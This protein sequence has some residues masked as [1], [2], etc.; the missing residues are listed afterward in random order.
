ML[1]EGEEI[2]AFLGAGR[3]GGDVSR[4]DVERGKQV[5]RAVARVGAALALNHRAP[6]AS[7]TPPALERL[8]RRLFVHTEH[9]SVHRRVQVQANDI[10]RFLGECGVEDDAP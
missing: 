2:L 4:L 9:D 1:H 5:A 6:G 3:L 10:G 7:K 8:N